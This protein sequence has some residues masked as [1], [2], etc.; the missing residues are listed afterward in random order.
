MTA[1]IKAVIIDDEES[2]RDI[3]NEL[4][5]RFCPNI[6]IMGKY[7]NLEDGVSGINQY[8]PEVAFIDIKMPKH[9]GFEIVNFFEKIDFELIFVTAYDNY[10]V[11]AFE[12]SAVD[13]LLKPIDI[14]KLKNAVERLQLKLEH[15]RVFNNYEALKENLKEDELKKLV[16][17]NVGEH[18]IIDIKDII[19]IEAQESYSLIHTHDNKILASKNLKHFENALNA[20]KYFFR[21]HKSWLININHVNSY[22]KRTKEIQMS[23]D[24]LAK[25]SK[26]RKIEFEKLIR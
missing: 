9:N 23:K 20:S 24:I 10:A 6:E 15:T 12:L 7:A 13:Y 25:L 22:S 21:C 1:K 11:N 4:L 2:A 3:L 17:P 16:I 5:S 18:K 19:A 26:L 8:H 14:E